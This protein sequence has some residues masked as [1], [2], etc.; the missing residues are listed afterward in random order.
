[1]PE[2]VKIE[3]PEKKA[4][5]DEESASEDETGSQVKKPTSDLR[6]ANAAGPVDLQ[7]ILAGLSKKKGD[8]YH[9]F[10]ISN[11]YYLPPINVV[12]FPHAAHH[13]DADA[14]RDGEAKTDVGAHTPASQTGSDR[15]PSSKVYFK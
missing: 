3:R 14:D 2:P 4:D 7:T 15:K 9:Y 11:V 5:S 12:Y 6:V 1:S 8:K 10:P 13:T